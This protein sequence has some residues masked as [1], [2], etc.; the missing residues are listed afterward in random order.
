M[1]I[2]QLQDNKQPNKTAFRK[3]FFKTEYNIKYINT[4]L[5]SLHFQA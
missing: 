3:I 2:E 4:K 1:V 5:I